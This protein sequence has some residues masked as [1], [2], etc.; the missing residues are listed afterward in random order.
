VG[1]GGAMT[2]AMLNRAKAAGCVRTVLH[3]SERAVDLY[4]RAG[5]VPRCPLTAYAT[6]CV[7]VGGALIPGSRLR[8][9]AGAMSWKQSGSNLEVTDRSRAQQAMC[10][11]LS[12]AVSDIRQQT[13]AAVRPESTNVTDNVVTGCASIM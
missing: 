6:K 4:R 5:F 3:S 12:V 2:V 1:S 10:R 7:V 11:P 9:N 8:G 13:A